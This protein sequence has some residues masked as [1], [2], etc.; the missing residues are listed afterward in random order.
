[1]AD[2]GCYQCI[3]NYDFAALSGPTRPQIVAGPGRLR[4]HRAAALAER[5]RQN[6]SSSRG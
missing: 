5:F 3:D 6:A 2:L 4:S 1:M